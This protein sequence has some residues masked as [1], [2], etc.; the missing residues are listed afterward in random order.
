MTSRSRNLAKRK[1]D[2]LSND[3]I[4]ASY[5]LCSL[6]EASKRTEPKCAFKFLSIEFGRSFKKFVL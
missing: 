6:Y 5:S 4:V 3:V 1:L 2:Q